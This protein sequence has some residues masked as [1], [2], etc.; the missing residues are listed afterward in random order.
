MVVLQFQFNFDGK[1][2]K[3][4]YDEEHV[5]EI[6]EFSTLI[7]SMSFA[8]LIDLSGHK[9]SSEVSDKLLKLVGPWMLNQSKDNSISDI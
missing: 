8:S 9:N 2:I 3:Q 5:N 4:C 6:V 7:S 1:T